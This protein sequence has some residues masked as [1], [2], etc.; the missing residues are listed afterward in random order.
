MDF[1]SHQELVTALRKDGAETVRELTPAK[2]ELWHYATGIGGEA[3]EILDVVKKH[4][5]YHKALD[6]EHLVEELGDLEWYME[7]LRQVAGITREETLA[8]NMAKLSK[9]YHEGKF[10]NAQAQ[11]R[12]DK[13]L[14]TE[15][16]RI[17]VAASLDEDD[18][19]PR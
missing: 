12:A 10:T 1:S 11:N 8:H 15:G 19:D 13:V 18:M 3:G 7:A 9:R 5:V 4:S 6:R 17:R 14:D 16:L 2:A